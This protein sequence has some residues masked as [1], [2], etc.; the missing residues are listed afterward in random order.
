MLEPIEKVL[1][2]PC[3]QETA[4]MVFV[5][6]GSWWPTNRF[7]TSVMRGSLV[8]ELRVEARAGGRIVEIAADGGE[9]LWGV[10]RTYD[11]YGYLELDFHIPHPSEQKPGFSRVEIRFTA[12]ADERTRVELKQ[13]NWEALGDVAKMVQG[14]Y[15]QAWTAI[16]DGAYMAACAT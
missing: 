15:R 6:M 12:L 7:A 10:I 11:P 2:V 8:T 16:L 1:E 14:G 13:S 4:F 3:D 5:D 9:T